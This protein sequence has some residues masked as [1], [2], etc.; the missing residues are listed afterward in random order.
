MTK[1]RFS[2]LDAPTIADRNAIIRRGRTERANNGV[3]KPVLTPES[4]AKNFDYEPI[5]PIARPEREEINKSFIKS[6]YRDE[7]KKALTS[8]KT[9]SGME[10]YKHSARAYGIDA[11]TPEMKN[12]KDVRTEARELAGMKL[13]N[14]SLTETVMDVM[15]FDEEEKRRTRNAF[16]GGDFS[17]FEGIKEKL[18]DIHG[19]NDTATGTP[20]YQL[21]LGM[22]QQ[23]IQN[24]LSNEQA[25]AMKG[26]K[27]FAKEVNDWIEK[28]PLNEAENARKLPA[29][30]KE[31]LRGIGN[32]G[33]LVV[34]GYEDSILKSEDPALELVK[35]FGMG[36][37]AGQVSGPLL[38]K[39][40]ILAKAP[41][42]GKTLINSSN[43]MVAQTIT[44][45]NLKRIDEM[46][47]DIAG[48]EY[49]S[50]IEKGYN[51]DVAR[52]VANTSG[53]AQVMVEELQLDGLGKM[54]PYLSKSKST[55]QKKATQSALHQLGG[56]A[57]LYGL[58]TFKGVS[59]EALEEVGQQAIST[60]ADSISRQLTDKAPLGEALING[61][62][63]TGA[64]MFIEHP[65]LYIDTAIQTARQVLL[66]G[67][68]GNTVKAGIDFK[69]STTATE[70]DYEKQE[71]ENAKS[72]K[73]IKALKKFTF[74][75]DGLSRV[76][77]KV[78]D[79][80]VTSDI[81][82]KVV[83]TAYSFKNAVNS[84]IKSDTSSFTPEETIKLKKIAKKADDTVRDYITEFK[85]ENKSTYLSD[86]DVESNKR[87][88][89]ELATN[90]NVNPMELHSFTDV[91][92]AVANHYKI[93]ENKPGLID[94]VHAL[95][96][97]GKSNIE[98]AEAIIPDL[99]RRAIIN[100]EKVKVKKTELFAMKL[101]NAIDT[102]DREAFIHANSALS[103]NLDLIQSVRVGDEGLSNPEPK[104]LATQR[105]ENKSEITDKMRDELDSEELKELSHNEIIDKITPDNSSNLEDNVEKE[106]DVQPVDLNTVKKN[107]DIPKSDVYRVNVD[108]IVVN[109]SAFQ[110]RQKGTNP[111]KFA[112]VKWNDR[113]GGTVTLYRDENGNLNMVNG[114]HR[115]EIARNSGVEAIDAR[116]IDSS[117][118][119]MHEARMQ[120]ALINIAED[121]ASPVDVAELFRN[122]EITPDE[123][124]SFGIRPNSNL[125]KMGKS[126]TKLDDNLYNMVINNQLSEER[127]SE[128]ANAFP[129]D[130]SK[131]LELYSILKEQENKGRIITADEIR[132]LK[133]ALY[134]TGDYKEGGFLDDHIR[135]TYAIEK[136]DLM[137]YAS[138]ELKFKKNLLSK[139]SKSK[140][141]NILKSLGNEIN[142]EGNSKTINESEIFN[143]TLSNAFKRGNKEL[144]SVID[145]FALRLRENPSDSY[146]KRSFLESAIKIIEDNEIDVTGLSKSDYV[147]NMMPIYHLEKNN[148]VESGALF[149]DDIKNNG[150][151]KFN[152]EI[153]SDFADVLN[154]TKG[155]VTLIN[156]STNNRAFKEVGV[157]VNHLVNN[158]YFNDT[159]FILDGTDENRFFSRE[160]LDR[161]GYKGY[162]EGNY[163][164]KGRYQKISG[165]RTDGV[166]GIFLSNGADKRTVAEETI[167]LIT[168]KERGLNSDLHKKIETWKENAINKADEYGIVLPEND[169]LFAKAFLEDRGGFTKGDFITSYILN[170]PDELYQDIANI[171]GEDF[172][173]EA[174][175]DDYPTDVVYNKPRYSKVD[176]DRNLIDMANDKAR[177][178]ASMNLDTDS[179]M[180]KDRFRGSKVLD[181]KGDPLI[182]YADTKHDFNVMYSVNDNGGREQYLRIEKPYK[183]DS[184]GD[185]DWEEVNNNDYDGIEIGSGRDTKYI[186]LD[187]AMKFSAYNDG[188]SLYELEPN[189]E[190][191][192]RKFYKTNEGS[193]SDRVDDDSKVYE[194][195]SNKAQIDNADKWIDEVGIEGVEMAVLENEGIL[196]PVQVVAS[197]K[198]ANELSDI[199]PDRASRIV[200]RLAENSTD[201]AQILQSY[202]NVPKLTALEA[203][204]ILQSYI[205][206]ERSKLGKKGEIEQNKITEATKKAVD[207]IKK[208]NLEAIKN[209][210]YSEILDE[211]DSTS[212]FDLALNN[213]RS[214]LNADTIKS[215]KDMST[216]FNIFEK[217]I[218][219]GNIPDDIRENISNS[220]NKNYS[221]VIK[222]VDRNKVTRSDVDDRL[223]KFNKAVY[224]H[225]KKGS[226]QTLSEDLEKAGFTKAVSNFLSSKVKSKVGDMTFADRT[227]LF[228]ELATN[229][230]KKNSTFNDRSKA[231]D[232]W[233]DSA[234]VGEKQIEGEIADGLGY[235]GVTEEMKEFIAEKGKQID[236]LEDMFDKNAELNKLINRLN[237]E[238]PQRTGDKL[239]SYRVIAML[240]NPKTTARNLVG[241]YG[242]GLK[243]TLTTGIISPMVDRL[244]AI[245]TGQRTRVLHNPIKNQIKGNVIGFKDGIRD[246]KSGL[247]LSAS[248]YANSLEKH[249]DPNSKVEIN[250]K[251]VMKYSEGADPLE[252]KSQ[253]GKIRITKNSVFDTGV[254]GVAEKALNYNLQVPDRAAISGHYLDRVAELEKIYEKA[255][256]KI[257]EKNRAFINTM[258]LEQGLDRTFND[259]NL[260]S[261]TLVEL[262]NV[263][264][265]ININGFGVGDALLPFAKVPVNV[266]VRGADYSPIGLVRGMHD[267]SKALFDKHLSPTDSFRIQ[268][269]G[270]DLVSRGIAGTIDMFGIG[271]L[272]TQLGILTP[273]RTG[274]DD[275]LDKFKKSL[276]YRKGSFNVDAF[277]R[278]LVGED[279]SLQPGDRFYD[280]NSL[281]PLATPIATGSAIYEASKNGNG[282]VDTTI[283][284]IAAGINSVLDLSM[285]QGVIDPIK[286]SDGEP[287]EIAKHVGISLVS[288]FVPTLSGAIATF[289]DPTQ[290]DVFRKDTFLN[291]VKNKTLSR[292]PLISK[293]VPTKK[294]VFGNDLSYASD[295]DGL[296]RRFYNSFLNTMNTS[297]YNPDTTTALLTYIAE[298]TG[299]TSIIPSEFKNN[300][301]GYKL[302]EILYNDICLYRGDLLKEALADDVEYY[303]NAESFDSDEAIKTLSGVVSKVQSQVRD[304]INIGLEELIKEG[305]A[306][307]IK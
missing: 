42:V 126:L 33:E 116:I 58:E 54:V 166:Q 283:K 189:I 246:V 176:L 265:K 155:A 201:V 9:Q 237:A 15:G 214:G 85:Q 243:D 14:I 293:S 276:G 123:L 146:L 198:I 209:I 21:R 18:E 294:D 39:A 205:K 23:Q 228:K 180:F 157:A 184:Y 89:L 168:E 303:A 234:F 179:K 279:T 218:L 65:E 177:V 256:I 43:G 80:R 101:I 114:H 35:A 88:L 202:S 167:H 173:R 285:L 238:F 28:H 178:F 37:V 117:E 3:G 119:N 118:I 302:D 188:S 185:I 259:D 139:V 63:D 94:K 17:T 108:D 264:N 245:K 113:L 199:D 134:D 48:G 26:E 295:G 72:K 307:K 2:I 247:N 280:Y 7:D 76:F 38:S 62:K 291:S 71:I 5:T 190:L 6:Q 158:E 226:Q 10:A 140:N 175:G 240:L 70:I 16:K 36:A 233:N 27:N 206:Q 221:K 241:N 151:Y 66:L 75:K 281:Q 159:V 81:K 142:V 115:L 144:R 277:K 12:K 172:I 156:N 252:F 135:E 124:K 292:I 272:L 207:R 275:K 98:I 204:G 171:V 129:D 164:I 141:V 289:I 257:D 300:F 46:R 56:L 52:I 239:K 304:E 290:K 299:D 53:L 217:D 211:L 50:M 51:P 86:S 25:K 84:A 4:F 219:S 149:R 269:K 55:I 260:A 153:N 120:G 253:S 97:E 19:I 143:Q 195:D 251:S 235:A 31:G 213:M 193:I 150:A 248:D 96:D 242:F 274:K 47:Q 186:L 203:E 220:E 161:Y 296:V 122:D 109:E 244:V 255:G 106:V 121:H 90:D 133:S 100:G 271:F 32:M 107:F 30:V 229:K 68:A 258:A 128:L 99:P 69:G 263:A 24:V 111:A 152:G 34:S 59:S 267:L 210:K 131:Q 60:Y 148:V 169:E 8:K 160:E 287:T 132:F 13:K 93:A 200:S 44:G 284:G 103:K 64:D 215:I 225:Y 212:D 301:N 268:N 45:M 261:T 278:F 187:S 127:A 57:K 92:R 181:F 82:A 208:G 305:L 110:F 20:L 145:T 192:E 40:P 163:K 147:E 91:N 112:N 232:K 125:F 282:A 191:G 249:R 197:W 183:A 67:V 288:S 227:E 49:M 174:F 236:F 266:A 130:T 95:K 194:K 170:V 41:I 196:T 136:M 11:R 78:K 104:Q 297:V 216:E 138:K 77:D 61:I 74:D 79:K 165:N 306:T 1:Q 254:L 262:R 270:V 182:V 224:D 230:G 29:I 250:D 102:V 73:E 231:F 83:D 162:E 286:Y 105:E 223:N 298:E 87:K 137:K 154:E 273:P 222:F 22:A